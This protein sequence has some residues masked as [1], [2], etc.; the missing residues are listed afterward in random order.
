MACGSLVLVAKI[1]DKLF[2]ITFV[3]GGGLVVK[4][5]KR[6]AM[7]DGRS[8][9]IGPP[10]AQSQKLDVPKKTKLFLDQTVRERESGKGNERNVVAVNDY[11]N[12]VLLHFYE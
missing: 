9:V 2:W 12:I 7:F 11:E 4:M 8:S 10:V 3:S 1:L 5:L 6:T